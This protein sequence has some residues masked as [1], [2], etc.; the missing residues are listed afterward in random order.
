MG[1]STRTATL[2]AAASVI[3]IS[4]GMEPALADGQNANNGI[5]IGLSKQKK[6]DS[7]QQKGS[8]QIKGEAFTVKLHNSQQIKQDSQQ[9]K[10]DAN[11][12]KMDS[13]Q[14]KLDS[15]QVKGGSIQQKVNAGALNPQPEPPG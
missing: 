3:A 5:L 13:N 8:Q 15:K 2:L 9:L 12:I 4:V 10:L 1:I 7:A 6:M 14:L 11:H